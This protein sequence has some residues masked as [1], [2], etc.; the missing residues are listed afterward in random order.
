MQPH[1]HAYRRAI[2]CRDGEHGLPRPATAREQRHL[3]R[4]RTWRRTRHPRSSRRSCYALRSRS[5]CTVVLV[6]E[7]GVVIA[8]VAKKAVLS[9]SPC[10]ARGRSPALPAARGV[11]LQHS[12]PSDDRRA[13]AH[14][15]CPTSA[16]YARGPVRLHSGRYACPLPGGAGLLNIPRLASSSARAESLTCRAAAPGRGRHR[17][18]SS[19]QR[20]NALRELWAECQTSV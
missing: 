18:T 1:T 17:A 6:E 15:C 3:G 20:C 14:S 8:K 9:P 13:C 16:R 11:S 5:Q 2:G 4:S 10:P 12:N 19:R 7:A